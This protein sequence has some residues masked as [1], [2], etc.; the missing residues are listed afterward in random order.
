LCGDIAARLSYDFECGAVLYSS[1]FTVIF[2]NLDT[3]M[4]TKQIQELGKGTLGRKSR[5]P[6]KTHLDTSQ[7][8][9]GKNSFTFEIERVQYL[10][11]RYLFKELLMD[12]WRQ[13]QGFDLYNIYFITVA[14]KLRF[15]LA[16]T[17]TN[18]IGELKTHLKLGG[19]PLQ[20]VITRVHK[21]N[22]LLFQAL[23]KSHPFGEVADKFVIDRSASNDT[24]LVINV[25]PIGAD[26]FVPLNV[27]VENVLEA[28]N[29]ELGLDGAPR[30]VYIGQSFRIIER[31]QSHKRINEASANLR[32]DEEL[33]INLVQFRTGYMGKYLD[34]GWKFFLSQHNP[35]S[36]EFKN[37]V[38][39]LER[40][41][42]SFFR[43]E[44]NDQHVNTE[45]RDD[46][47]VSQIVKRF[48]IGG[49]G[50]G[51]GVHGALGKYWS[52]QQISNDEVVSYS[53]S[54]PALGFQPG[55]NGAGLHL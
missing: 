54:N 43:P 9:E 33:R 12:T 55:L 38:S 10:P 4:D 14:K 28:E 46:Q 23:H 37:K 34:D 36:T 40:I 53:F 49:L 16:R 31:L 51:V 21:C 52:P 50:V 48:Q 15:D 3:L 30:I 2:I 5:L 17:S 20:R 25:T 7:I 27:L 42:I 29:V 18:M 35:R 11:H 44:L 6:S 41:L 13:T 19:I 47:L 1:T 45:L 32:D 22:P 8:K 26:S 39:L 24:K